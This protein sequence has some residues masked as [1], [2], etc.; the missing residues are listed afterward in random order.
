MLARLY[1]AAPFIM[2]VPENTPFTNFSYEDE[3]YTVT[4]RPPGRSDLPIYADVPDKLEVDGVPAFA[5]NTFQIEFRKE[6]FSRDKNGSIDPP[7]HVI[8]R[9]VSGLVARLRFVTRAFQIEPIEFL[10]GSW[11]LRYLHDDGT[12]LEENEGLVRGRGG[13][14]FSW[15]LVGVNPAVWN[16][17]HSLPPDWVP[18]PWDDILLDAT[19]ALPKVGTAVVLAATALEVFIADVLERVAAKGDI[20][21][22]VWY[23]INHRGDWQRDPSTEDQFDV[24]LKHF[25]GHSLKEDAKLWQ[26]FQNLRTA[27]NKFVHE[28]LARAGGKGLTPADAAQLLSRAS[29]IVNWVRQWLPPDLQWPR[30]QPPLNLVCEMGI[31]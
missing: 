25:V 19:A 2:V 22:D 4:I 26:G 16:D 9:A 13:R 14:A 18:P 1:V 20:P 28:G 6:T 5:A 21:S 31:K 8:R 23:W 12:E 24:L 10:E 30:F 3:G 29:E 27:R 17:V 15:S 7:E 11:R